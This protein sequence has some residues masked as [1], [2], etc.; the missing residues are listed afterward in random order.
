LV[1][2]LARRLPLTIHTGPQVGL[3]GRPLASRLPRAVARNRHQLE[4]E[5][6]SGA[7]HLRIPV[8]NGNPGRRFFRRHHLGHPHRG[9]GR[10]ARPD[11]AAEQLSR[12]RR[13]RS[14]NQVMTGNF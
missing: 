9:T 4:D 2:G 1:S 12:A 7:W 8:E 5:V 14:G 3:G 6:P 13:Q 11:A 10:H